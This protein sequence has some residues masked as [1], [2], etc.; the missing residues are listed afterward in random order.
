MNW[1]RLL[2]MRN[3]SG[4]GTISPGGSSKNSIGSSNV[5]SG[6]KDFPPSKIPSDP[7]SEAISASNFCT[8]KLLNVNNMTN[9]AKT[10]VIMS[11]YVTY[12]AVPASSVGCPRRRRLTDTGAHHTFLCTL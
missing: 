1:T 11:E 3:I 9:K 4:L 8:S 5:S 12:H 2:Y 10:N 7:W 6:T